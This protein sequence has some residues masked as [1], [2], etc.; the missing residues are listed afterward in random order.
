M[1]VRSRTAAITPSMSG[2][3][4]WVHRGRGST[5]APTTAARRRPGPDGPLGDRS[6]DPSRSSSRCGARCSCRKRSGG[7]SA[8][9]PRSA[10]TG[11]PPSTGSG[12]R[13]PAPSRA[14]ARRR[15]SSS[16]PSP[17]ASSSAR[18]PASE[19]RPG[20]AARAPAR[21]WPAP[22]PRRLGGH[23]RE[24]ADPPPDREDLVGRR[25]PAQGRPS[26]SPAAL[27]QLPQR[28]GDVVRLRPSPVAKRAATG[29]AQL[30]AGS[31]RGGRRLQPAG[32]TC[33][34]VTASRESSS[35][36]VG[37][38]PSLDRPGL[39]W[40]QIHG[41]SVSNGQV[42]DRSA[43]PAARLNR[44][45]T[46]PRLRSRRGTCDLYAPG[47]QIHYRHQGDAVRSPGRIGQQRD[48]R[49]Q[50]G[51]PG[52]RRPHASCT[53]GTTSRSGCGGSSSWCRASASPTPTTTRCGSGP[54]WFNCATETTGWQDCRVRTGP[55]GREREPSPAGPSRRPQVAGPPALGVR[56]ASCSARTSTASGSAPASAP[57]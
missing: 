47:H 24:R 3:N 15:A 6:R 11:T 13:A 16:S 10:A 44:R 9:R 51:D 1:P 40:P 27:E 57:R 34:A 12:R 22:A 39:S 17:T 26:S 43:Q 2:S 56:R 49:R 30:E 42:L 45:A 52:P 48:R 7:M 54:Y 21:G 4:S 23:V 18:T 33:A 53:G 37:H 55:P 8:S 46:G 14:A 20:P 38:P 28:P 31:S 41:G 36:P 29:A 25:G 32:P 35:A 50:P 19:R 5:T